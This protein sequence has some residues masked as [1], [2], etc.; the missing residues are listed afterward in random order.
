MKFG[1]LATG[2]LALTL[3]PQPAGAAPQPPLPIDPSLVSIQSEL[4]TLDGPKGYYST[5]YRPSE[6]TYWSNLPGWMREEAKR[7]TVARVL[8]IGCG[9]G[10]LLAFAAEVFHAQPFCIDVVHYFP[11]FGERRGFQFAKGNIQL[12]P[13][14]WAGG[15]DAIL[16]TEVLEHFNFQPLPT[17]KKIHDALKPDG[18]FYLTTP[19]AAEWGKQTKYYS[20]LGDLPPADPT[21][22][23]IDDHVWVYSKDELLQLVKDA[24]FRVARF[25]YSPG[26][27]HRHFNLELR[28]DA[29]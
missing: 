11:Q 7:H 10:T 16:M 19:D 15:F 25:A 5:T 12:D 6:T 14:P 18:V 13:I 20:R 21:K 23:F 9:Y 29:K 22:P 8:D 24:G 3:S 28:R 1:W 26:V 17:L 4:A 2:L 27:G